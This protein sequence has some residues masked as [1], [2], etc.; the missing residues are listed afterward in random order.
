MTVF[1][2]PSEL[3]EGSLLGD[4]GAD[5]PPTPI[6][7]LE[8]W[9]GADLMIS[10]APF[11]AMTETLVRAHVT[12]GALL[13]QRKTGLDLVHSIGERMGSSLAR[14]RNTGA[15]QSQCVL[16]YIGVLTCNAQNE[17]VMDGRETHAAFWGVQGAISKW[18]DRGGVVEAISR[19]SLLEGWLKMKLRHLTEY[20]NE[21]V[22]DNWPPPPT[23]EDFNNPL[24]VPQ[25]VK[26]GRVTL[27][28]LPGVGS[29]RATAIWNYLQPRPTLAEA[30]CLLTNDNSRIVQDVPGIGKKTAENIRNYLGLD[31]VMEL[32]LSVKTRFTEEA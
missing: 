32:M 30:L 24:Q 4:L 27:A 25:V 2:D 29:A 31:E 10:I 28:T 11:P 15:R 12:A 7:G 8:E 1:V 13:V 21:P 9:T 26:D 3:R 16:L 14:M 23:I 17:A 5:F 18:H 19:P 22:K 6:S 20:K